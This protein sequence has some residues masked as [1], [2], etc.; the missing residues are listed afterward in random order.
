[1]TTRLLHGDALTHLKTL[2]DASVHC[3]I[4]SPPY[5]GL[6]AYGGEL[7]MIGFEP[8]LSE[9]IDNLL[10]VFQEV[11]RVL[12]ADSTL[13]LNYSSA[14]ASSG[15]TVSSQNPRSAPRAGLSAYRDQRGVCELG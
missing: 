14:Y 10:A 7:G 2:P 13:W 3:V 8:T 9:H 4:T 12:R 11:W 1:M 15:D 5:W 6:R